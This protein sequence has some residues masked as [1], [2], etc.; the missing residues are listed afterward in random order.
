MHLRAKQSKLEE[1]EIRY[2][3]QDNIIKDMFD[4]MVELSDKAY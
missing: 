1:L 2:V 3:E 4:D